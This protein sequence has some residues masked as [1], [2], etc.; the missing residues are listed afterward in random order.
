MSSIGCE[1]ADGQNGEVSNTITKLTK[2][3]HEIRTFY[4][5]VISDVLQISNRHD[6]KKRAVVGEVLKWFD[7]VLKWDK[8]TS[9]VTIDHVPGGFMFMD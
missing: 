2:Y 6:D 9:D 8:S 7:E 4:K 1:F 5:N 3:K